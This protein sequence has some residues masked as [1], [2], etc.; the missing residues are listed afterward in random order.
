MERARDKLYRT[1]AVVLRRVDVGEADRVLTLYT[2]QRGKFRAIA[3]GVR[4]PTSHLGGHL[5]LFIRSRLLL[6]KGRDLD[7]V[8]QAETVDPFIAFRDDPVLIW[9]PYYVAELLDRFSADNIENEV[10]Y[11]LLLD[12]LGWIGRATNLDLLMRYYEVQLLGLL[13][14]R[15]EL[16]R[17]LICKNPLQPTEGN[18]FSVAQGGMLCPACAPSQRAAAISL[19]VFK[20]LRLLQRSR[21]YA[22][23]N[24]VRVAETVGAEVKRVMS[25]YLQYI[26]EREPRSAQ[27]LAHAHEGEELALST[28]PHYPQEVTV[29]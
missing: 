4:R 18:A 16:E 8:T 26:I 2:P 15:P 11:H 9:Y 13:G 17:C 20:V 12:T 5:E 10:V 1:E 27:F 22:E 21:S 3:K 23:V 19:P 25:S 14:Y 6:A 29:R 28:P 24:R 7:Y